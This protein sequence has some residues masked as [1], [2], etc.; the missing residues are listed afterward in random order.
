[1]IHFSIIIPTY[2]RS[3]ELTELLNCL[4]SQTYKN[5]EVI[6][7]DDGSTDSTSDIIV[8]YSSLL[9]I[10]YLLLENSGG[11]ALP[12]NIGIKNAKNNWLCFVD[13]DDLWTQNKLEILA[14][15]IS[16]YP[17]YSIFCHPVY[18]I[19]NNFISTKVIGNYKRGVFLNDFKSLLYNGS[20]VVNSSLCVR[21]TILENEIYYNTSVEFHGIEDYIFL[22]DLT[23]CNNKIKNINKILGYYRLHNNNIS[24]DNDKQLKK[25]KY[26]FSNSNFIGVNYN[27]IN[28]GLKYI[29]NRQSIKNKL[30]IYKSYLKIIFFNSSFEIKIKSLIKMIKLFF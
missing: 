20:Q 30:E 8:E 11:P 22:L 14:R 24:A 17:E 26:Y 9:D 3:L 4:V 25:L 6:V 19:E 27:K 10:K 18:I 2:N 1:M 13:S 7:C 21:K 16:L 15:S 28:S 5:F 29:E 12:R 23:S